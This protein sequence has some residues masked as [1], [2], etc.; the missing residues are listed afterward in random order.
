MSVPA[1]VTALLSPT[2]YPHPVA[3]VRLIETHISWVLLAGE[4]A[5]KIKKPVNLGFLDFSTL[6]QR[7]FCCDEEIRLNRRLEPATY[8]EV[9]AITGNQDEPVIQGDGPVLDWAVRMR[10]FPADATLDREPEI[11]SDQIDAIAD[12]I[13]RFHKTVEPSPAHS[14]YGTPESVMHPVREN[15]VQLRELLKDADQDTIRKIDELDRWSEAEG[16]QLERYFRV[17]KTTDHIRECHGDLHLGNIAWDNG[18][19][20]IFDCIE[21]NPSLRHIDIISEA[22]F[23]FMDLAERGHAGLAWRFLNR[24]L[25]HTGDFGGLEGLR[26]YLVYRAMVRAKVAAIRSAQT[27]KRDR[28]EVRHYLDLAATFC[29]KPKVALILMHG[30]SGSGKTW[31]S[32]RLLEARGAIRLRSDVERKRLFGLDALEDSSTIPGGIYGPEASRHTLN[33]LLIDAESL[34]DSGFTVIVDAT[35][36]ARSWRQPFFSSARTH[37]W[38]IRI[39]AMNVPDEIM[40]QRIRAREVLS[41]DASEAGL[42]ILESQLVHAEPLDEVELAATCSF[43]PD[44]T[45]DWPRLLDWLAKD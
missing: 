1:F 41:N 38:H 24:W 19:P 23:L 45:E 26:F 9:V 40:R 39:V 7:R 13:A 14:D 28:D 22:A 37:G 44:E 11:T 34:L 36:L 16:V 5:Y 33:H 3:E 27:E 2:A 31:L 35:F 8:L 10:A 21:F 42:E 20:I 6:D 25:E 4:F 17:R 29:R 30:H 32:Q 18:V 43:N 15:F 12:R